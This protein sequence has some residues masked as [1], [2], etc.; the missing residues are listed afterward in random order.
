MEKPL[1]QGPPSAGS[2]DSALTNHG[3]LQAERLGRHLASAAIIFTD[4]FSSDLQRAFKTAEAIR[5]L[6]PASAVFDARALV[7]IPLPALREQDFGYYEGKHF[8]A[9]SP[10]SNKTGKAVHQ[11]EHQDDPAFQDVESR[12]S[13]NIRADAFLNDHLWPMMI[14]EGPAEMRVVAVVAHGIIL[15]VLW[16]RLLSRFHLDNVVA[17]PGIIPADRNRSIEHLGGWSNTGYLELDLTI[18]GTETVPPSKLA[19]PAAIAPSTNAENGPSFA[20]WS[21]LIKTVNGTDHLKG[22]RKTRGGVGSSKHD[23]SQ[24]KIDTFFKRNKDS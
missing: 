2:R 11:E 13:M 16:K 20:D 9:R 7:T 3:V 4:L 18:G 24:V 19:S 6:Q 14:A 1:T 23:E 10:E 22:L 17:V 8:L 5:L 21:L 15:S 12:E